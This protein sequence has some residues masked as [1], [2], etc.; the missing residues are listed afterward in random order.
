MAEETARGAE[1]T[2]GGE[3]DRPLAGLRDRLPRPVRTAL[4]AAVDAPRGLWPKSRAYRT[5][6]RLAG[7]D[8]QTYRDKIRYRLAWDR[9]PFL[10]TFADKVAMRDYVADRVGERH[11]PELYGVWD[12]AEDIDWGSLP[13]GMAI[14]AAHGS[15]G[16]I[17]RW[18]GA[19]RGRHLPAV[20]STALWTRHLVHPDDCDVDRATALLAYWLTLSYEHGPHRL[21]EW[22]YSQVPHR[23]LAE[24]LMLDPS[25]TTV[26]PDY[27]FLVFD[28]R[29]SHIAV[30]AERF[31]GERLALM[32]PDWE[33]LPV[34][35][36]FGE[37]PEPPPPPTSLSDAIAMAE[38]LG[39]GLDYVRVDLYDPGDR[40]VVGELTASP[41]GGLAEFEP[42]E[43]EAL[44]G[45]YWTIPDEV[46]ENRARML[47]ARKR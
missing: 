47:A 9:R 1:Q 20:A 19:P 12:R 24:E 10:V 34:A 8:P 38:T 45:T 29:V 28:G 40:L 11:L 39:E 3:G 37:M 14:K 13:E 31:S 4:H 17:V 5:L 33:Q 27:K 44:I 7:D 16:V 23:I 21:P 2:R 43:Y 36:H 35:S 32:T 15:G 22:A 46:R 42:A 6:E 41:G 30:I 26:A 25:R 18:D